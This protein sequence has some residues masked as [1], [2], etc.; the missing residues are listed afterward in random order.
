VLKY[1]VLL[2]ERHN[3]PVSSAVVL[4]RSGTAGP[5]LTGLYRDR[6][7]LDGREHRFPYRV[8]RVWQQPVEDVLA[9]GVGTLPLAPLARVRRQALP[10]VLRRMRERLSAETSAERRKTLWA[11]TYVLMGLRYSQA[12]TEQLLQGVL[13]MEESVTYQ[14]II[15]RGHVEEAQRAVLRVGRKTLG[16]P[17]AAAVT[18]VESITDRDRLEQLLDRALDVS[19]WQELLQPP[20]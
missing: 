19:S 11:A 14:A 5:K 7:R 6:H 1:N 3:M 10:A 16:P 9:G 12:L 8:V 17:D 15:R 13:G 2:A 18:A 4:L 20:A